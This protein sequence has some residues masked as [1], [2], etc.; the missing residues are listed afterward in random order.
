MSAILTS[1]SNFMSA[2]LLLHNYQSWEVLKK[3]TCVLTQQRVC[4]DCEYIDIQTRELDHDFDLWKVTSRNTIS[5]AGSDDIIGELIR[6]ERSCK[7]CG[8]SEIHK[9]ESRLERS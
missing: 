2:C 1:R 5:K 3:T 4:D 6:Q 9:Q 7:G 8:F